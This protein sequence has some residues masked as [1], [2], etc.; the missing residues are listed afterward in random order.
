[1]AHHGATTLQ[2]AP[3]PFSTVTT[4]YLLLGVLAAVS[5]WGWWASR[6]Q[7]NAVRRGAH[8]GANSHYTTAGVAKRAYQSEDA[9]RMVARRIER[10]DHVRMDAYRCGQCPAWHVGH[11]SSSGGRR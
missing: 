1:V 11:A 4:G 2:H 6:S 9:A 7:R 3:D 10:Q 8:R 5:I